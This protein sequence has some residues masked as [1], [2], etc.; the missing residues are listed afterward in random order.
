MDAY[1][2]Q[3]TLRI[4]APT[5]V[6]DHIDRSRWDVYTKV[7][8]LPFVP[9]AGLQVAMG[10]ED[11]DF[12]VCAV[13]WC[14]ATAEVAPGGYFAAESCAETEHPDPLKEKLTQAGWAWKPGKEDKPKTNP[15]I[16]L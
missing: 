3:M 11:W 2:L 16:D 15:G 1:L 9:F 4:A 10:H 8:S 7:V 13:R 12:T 14:P 6:K 5:W